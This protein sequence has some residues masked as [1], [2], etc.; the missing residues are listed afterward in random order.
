MASTASTIGTIPT[1]SII[2]N[3]FF[4]V[5]SLENMGP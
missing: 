5:G 4:I 3:A 1:V 2:P